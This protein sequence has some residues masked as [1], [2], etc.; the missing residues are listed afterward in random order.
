[1][2]KDT[3]SPEYQTLKTEIRAVLISSQNGCT[4]R[5][6]IRDY[7]TYNSNAQIP[8]RSMG[9][10]S[11]IELLVSMPDV[12]Y[13]DTRRSPP[14]IMGVADESTKHLQEL[15][16]R[17]KSKKKP[18][19]RRDF[20]NSRA[21]PTVQYRPA[22]T[23]FL[24]N[25]YNVPTPVSKFPSFPYQNVQPVTQVAF[26]V[27]QATTNSFYPQQNVQETKN[28]ASFS[29]KDVSP[30]NDDNS[31]TTDDDEP[32][33]VY[34][35]KHA[36]VYGDAIIFLR[37]RIR[38]LLLQYSTGCWLK[39]IHKLYKKA[40][41]EEF[42]LEDFRL[43][44]LLMFFDC[45]SDFVDSQ[46]VK[47][48]EQDRLI[49]LKENLIKLVKK[50]PSIEANLATFL[51]NRNLS[52]DQKINA[53]FEDSERVLTTDDQLNFVSTD[54]RYRRTEYHQKEPFE[55]FLCDVEDPHSLSIGNQEFT[56]IRETLMTKLQD[57]Y[58][59]V[60][61]H[62]DY[63]L[64]FHELT[65]NLACVY[66]HYDRLYYRAFIEEIDEAE[67]NDRRVIRVR[68][69]DFGI[70]VDKILYFSQSTVLKHLHQDFTSPSI[71]IY[72]CRLANIDLPAN[73]ETWPKAAKT[74]I[75]DYC[76]E[77]KFLVEVIQVLDSI[78]Y[79]ELWLDEHRQQS[80]NRLLIQ[81]QFAI[82]VQDETL[83]EFEPQQ[84][85]NSTDSNENHYVD[86][87][88]F[89]DLAPHQIEYSVEEKSFKY[90]IVSVEHAFYFVKQPFTKRPCLP[91]FEL[92][93]LLNIDEDQL[94]N[95]NIIR[96]SDLPYDETSQ[97]VFK[98]FYDLPEASNCP[99]FHHDESRFFLK[100][101][102]L[103]G[104]R[105]YL[106][107]TKQGDG[108]LL[109]A[110]AQEHENFS[111]QGYWHE[112]E[113][114]FL[115]EENI[116]KSEEILTNRKDLL[117][118]RR[119]QLTSSNHFE[120]VENV[121]HQIEEIDEKL[122]NIHEIL[123]PTSI[124][125]SSS[126]TPMPNKSSKTKLRQTLLRLARPFDRHFGL[127]VCFDH[128]QIDL[129]K[130]DNDFDDLEEFFRDLHRI[131]DNVLQFFRLEREILHPDDRKFFDDL[132]NF[133][134]ELI[135]GENWTRRIEIYNYCL[136]V[137]QQC[138]PIIRGYIQRTDLI[139]SI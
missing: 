69:V 124:E 117:N 19:S 119:E 130:F 58:T 114:H 83:T 96:T 109:D 14:V 26:L 11:L 92:A 21:Y 28:V 43:K 7:G 32:W 132:T 101:Y 25:S 53:A 60:F 42:K 128:Q 67:S 86:T 123:R 10:S 134:P 36:E 46:R 85:S 34:D 105:E 73:V 100:L 111:R 38:K 97:D 122:K 82:R 20:S 102:D 93:R 50:E 112:F 30:T 84:R 27:P 90:F 107:K 137:V 81:R 62:P 80:I 24:L 18:V 136:N 45:I 71:Q 108:D 12:A 118:Y 94:N 48:D 2:S 76:K 47:T 8:Y 103:L 61:D 6:L 91:C 127:K 68:L 125:F 89:V 54:F 17:Q 131:T 79:V 113:S 59:S 65:L 57:H 5:E 49:K 88:H 37:Q 106:I 63:T 13:I 29:P 110:L 55:G 44:N 121:E 99:H 75:L 138:Q 77:T 1:M 52:S 98:H 41:N 129:A 126:P 15:V 120:E 33:A 3:N 74:L 87:K 64:K 56:N 51:S 9:F 22:P 31:S 115:R 40:F 133:L 139:D 70:S 78:Y 16:S 4:E 39:T 72:D 35:Y 116:V 104:V 95:L 66:Y 135:E 23:H